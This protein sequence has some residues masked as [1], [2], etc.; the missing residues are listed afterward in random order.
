MQLCFYTTNCGRTML[1]AVER[2]S[3]KDSEPKAIILLFTWPPSCLLPSPIQ[4]KVKGIPKL[5]KVPLYIPSFLILDASRS[6]C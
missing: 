2:K 6:L 4:T 1:R 5:F 3:R